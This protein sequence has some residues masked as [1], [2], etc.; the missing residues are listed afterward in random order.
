MHAYFNTTTGDKIY[1]LKFK[2][3]TR[4]NVNELLKLK[5]DSFKNNTN[6]LILVSINLQKNNVYEKDN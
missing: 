6:A 5:C 4:R 1:I 2:L 3:N